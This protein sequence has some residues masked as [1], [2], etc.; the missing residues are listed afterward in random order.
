MG[1]CWVVKCILPP[2]SCSC[3]CLPSPR[4]L[5]TGFE[6]FDPKR[7]HCG[8]VVIAQVRV[9]LVVELGEDGSP[10]SIGGD[11]AIVDVFVHFH[12]VLMEC[13]QT[14][15]VGTKRHHLISRLFEFGGHK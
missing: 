6:L 5:S 7:L 1:P 3:C 10:H 2:R 14:S 9:H 8:K 15:D 12:T 13:L 4:V 11:V